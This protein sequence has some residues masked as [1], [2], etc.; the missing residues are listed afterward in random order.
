MVRQ[1]NT[2]NE[3][4]CVP[5]SSLKT[6]FAE[7]PDPECEWYGRANLM[8]VNYDDTN[9]DPLT[10]ECVLRDMGEYETLDMYIAEAAAQQEQQQQEDRV[11]EAEIDIVH[12]I[13]WTETPSHDALTNFK[14]KL[15]LTLRKILVGEISCTEFNSTSAL[16][17]LTEVREI[18]EKQAKSKEEKILDSGSIKAIYEIVNEVIPPTREFMANLSEAIER[19]LSDPIMCPPYDKLISELPKFESYMKNMVKI[20]AHIEK[21]GGVEQ[22]DNMLNLLVLKPYD[23]FSVMLQHPEWLRY[24]VYYEVR[25]LIKYTPQHHEDNAS[26]RKVLEY[27]KPTDN[28]T[29]MPNYALVKSGYAVHLLDHKRYLCYLFLFPNFLFITRPTLEKNEVRY[30]PYYSIMLDNDSIKTYDMEFLSDVRT[31]DIRTTLHE[32]QKT[33]KQYQII[34]DMAKCMCEY[35]LTLL[36][37]SLRLI[38]QEQNGHKNMFLFSSL[39]ELLTWKDLISNSRCGENSL[40]HSSGTLNVYVHQI[41]SCDSSLPPADTYV[42][43][44]VDSLNGFFARVYRTKVV[45]ECIHPVYD[46]EFTIPTVCSRSLKISVFRCDAGEEG[47]KLSMAGIYDIWHGYLNEPESTKCTSAIRLFN[48]IQKPERDLLYHLIQHLATLYRLASKKTPKPDCMIKVFASVLLVPLLPSYT[49]AEFR[50][51]ADIFTA[52]L[53]YLVYLR[54]AGITFQEEEESPPKKGKKSKKQCSRESSKESQDGSKRSERRC[55]SDI[56]PKKKGKKSKKQSTQEVPQ[57]GAKSGSRCFPYDQEETPKK[58]GK[59]SKKASASREVSKESYAS[60]K[61]GASSTN[62]PKP[63]ESM[64]KQACRREPSNGCEIPFPRCSA[65]GIIEVNPPTDRETSAESNESQRK[66][67]FTKSQESVNSVAFKSQESVKSGK[68]NASQGRK[69]SFLGKLCRKKKDKDK[70]SCEDIPKLV[71]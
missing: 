68:S 50:G 37:P 26:L 31:D 8:E 44:E 5:D 3:S 9:I 53:R 19:D 2:P 38:I 1:S 58:K 34:L 54:M 33:R 46:E 17:N 56:L 69:K 42:T 11:K 41:R 61:S 24:R 71:D 28:I 27:L 51:K 20:K 13:V 16:L 40:L 10:L 14:L 25:E 32:L 60:V 66:K 22:V 12:P 35:E 67:A 43:L 57:D 59:K 63:D 6:H 15:L 62:D 49:N 7:V 70:V 39:V 52:V 18:L 45:K 29:R 21:N 48:T 4:C 30:K 65:E 47:F 23:P 64:C 36:V 55:F